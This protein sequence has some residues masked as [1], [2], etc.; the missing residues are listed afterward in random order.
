MTKGELYHVRKGCSIS[1]WVGLDDWHRLIH[2][3]F[4]IILGP[5]QPKNW[6]I[7]TKYGIVNTSYF[8]LSNALE[9]IS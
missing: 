9:I 8:Q 1:G 3:D 2:K 5:T 6:T 4:A 7:L